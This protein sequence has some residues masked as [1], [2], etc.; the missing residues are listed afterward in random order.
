MK[1]SS[2]GVLLI[3]KNMA[4]ADLHI[5]ILGFPDLTFLERLVDLYEKSKASRLIINGDLKHRLGKTELGSAGRLIRYLEE[6]VSELIIVRGNHDGHLDQIAEVH[7]YFRDG[8]TVFAHGHRKYGDMM[9]GK[10]II[11]AHTHP[12]VFIQDKVGG[13]KERAWLYGKSDEREYIVMPA[14][15]EYCSST[16]VNLEKPAGFIF[17]HLREFEA[18]TLDGFYF[19]KVLI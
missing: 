16:A 9:D 8:N 11:L 18:F 17:R 15:N 19:G 10:R 7:G 14:F 1:I 13:V 12:A 6:C 5:G 2:D 4:V 3:G